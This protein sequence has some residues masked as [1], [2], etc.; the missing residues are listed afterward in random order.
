MQTLHARDLHLLMRSVSFIIDDALF[1]QDGF[2]DSEECEDVSID[3][4]GDVNTTVRSYALSE[5]L[6]E[7]GEEFRVKVSTVWWG[8]A[9]RITQTVVITRYVGMIHT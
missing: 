5:L 8:R 7:K 6:N 2:T 4:Q 3:A 9:Y 1:L